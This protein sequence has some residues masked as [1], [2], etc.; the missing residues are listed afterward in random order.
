MVFLF[1][2]ALSSANAS[3]IQHKKQAG[4]RLPL[5]KGTVAPLPWGKQATILLLAPVPANSLAQLRV[6]PC[7]QISPGKVEK[8][9]S[10]PVAPILSLGPS[11]TS[12]FLKKQICI[13]LYF[14][15][16]SGTQNSQSSLNSSILTLHCLRDKLGTFSLMDW[17]T[18][19]LFGEEIVF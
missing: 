7:W 9:W 11:H 19:S 2:T 6:D 3:C 17:L 1:F 16:V 18:L 12:Q 8:L 14:Q 5:S 15:Q 10:V 4:W 13:Q